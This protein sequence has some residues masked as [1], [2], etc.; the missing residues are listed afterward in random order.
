MHNTRPSYVFATPPCSIAFARDR[1]ARAYIV[2][3]RVTVVGPPASRLRCDTFLGVSTPPP[4]DVVVAVS[5]TPDVISS[6]SSP[7]FIGRRRPLWSGIVIADAAVPVDYDH[8]WRP[9]QY[10]RGSRAVLLLLST[11][12]FVFI[13]QFNISIIPIIIIVIHYL[14]CL[15]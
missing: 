14:Q 6:L 2:H 5:P 10:Y 15:T 8:W 4:R 12:R 1:I 13:Y 7:R 9:S 3:V 11:L